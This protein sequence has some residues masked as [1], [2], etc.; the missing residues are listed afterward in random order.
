MIFLSKELLPVPWPEAF[1]GQASGNWLSVRNGEMAGPT[2][3]AIFLLRDAVIE[4][5]VSCEQKCS[6]EWLL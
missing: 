5:R 3:V 6:P 2:L 4:L 1:G